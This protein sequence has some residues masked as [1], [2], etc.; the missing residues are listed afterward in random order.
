MDDQEKKLKALEERAKRMKV[1]FIDLPKYKLSEKL[2]GKVP[3]TFA[4]QFKMIPVAVFGNKLMVGMENPGDL[5]IQEQLETRTKMKILPVLA[6]TEDIMDAIST[7]YSQISAD[8]I[9]LS[10]LKEP[11]FEAYKGYI[12]PATLEWLKDILVK[13]INR[14]ASD[15]HI[16]TH[17][18]EVRIRYRIDG[19]ISETN[20]MPRE[21]EAKIFGMIKALGKMMMEKRNVPQEGEISLKVR[22][23]ETLLRIGILPTLHGERCFL[24]LTDKWQLTVKI[25]ELGIDTE[26]WKKLKTLVK[27]NQGLIIFSGP[28]G[29]GVSTTLHSVAHYIS[30]SD[31]NVFTIE[32]PIESAIPGVNQVEVNTT[33]GMSTI[34]LIKKVSQHDPDVL[35]V[36]QV[37]NRDVARLLIDSALSGQLVLGGLY[38]RDAV[39]TITRIRDFGI[40]PYFISTTLLGVV[41]QRLVRKVCEKCSR[42]EKIPMNLTR[43]M[44]NYDIEH[45]GKIQRGRGCPNCLGTG[46]KGRTALF[47]IVPLS[48]S[49]KS[50]IISG[51]SKSS[52]E[53]QAYRDG[54][55]GLY[56][57]GLEK[58]AKG[59]TTFEEI[60]R[61]LIS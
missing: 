55:K 57:N 11:D 29:S 48:E 34:E 22:D 9:E 52:L 39:D 6:D 26:N 54:L 25:K 8:E 13:A 58:V 36:H 32:N 44:Q 17:E 40:E 38:A 5:Y 3:Y 42:P 21:S 46:Y 53:D 28:S 41:A 37:K 30:R 61:V 23:R 35:M 19:V 7:V 20:T 14:N 45:T 27:R 47:E 60:K 16:E 49:L 31:I 4:R 51:A 43:E 50:L 10:V 18:N 1:D 12:D 56:Q 24:R 59:I 2:A 33:S 15:I